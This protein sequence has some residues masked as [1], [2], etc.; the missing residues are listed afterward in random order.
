MNSD[1]DFRIRFQSWRQIESLTSP[2]QA[3][4]RLPNVKVLRVSPVYISDAVLPDNAPPDWNT[5]FLNVVICCE[6]SNEPEALL[7][8]L[9]NIEQ[10]FGRLMNAAR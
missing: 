10:S 6:T 3:I 2:L 7:K 9:K 1:G 8:Q 4:K 5:P